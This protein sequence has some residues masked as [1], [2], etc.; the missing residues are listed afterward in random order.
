[1][2]SK[3]LRFICFKCKKEFLFEP[4]IDPTTKEGFCKGCGTKRWQIRDLMGNIVE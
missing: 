1:M 3:L 4:T 2:L